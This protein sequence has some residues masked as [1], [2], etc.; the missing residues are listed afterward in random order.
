MSLVGNRISDISSVFERPSV[1]SFDDFLVGIMVYQ[2]TVLTPSAGT[3][4]ARRPKGPAGLT[5]V[6]VPE[7]T[8]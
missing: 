1:T 5:T 8:A 2:S 6:D 7:F 4:V 3:V